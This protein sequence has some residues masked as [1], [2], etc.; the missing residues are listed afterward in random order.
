MSDTLRG[1]LL[2]AGAALT[3]VTMHLIVRAVTSGIHPLEAAFFRNIVGFI[4]LIPFLL[5]QDRSKWKSKRPGLQFI[6]AVV[7]IGALFT[8]FTALSML[9]VADATALSFTSVLFITLGAAIFLKEGLGIRRAIAIGIG[10]CGTLIIVR[11]GAGVFDTGALVALGS[12]VLWAAALL[13]VKVLA[14]TDTSVTL[15]FYTNVYFTLF[16]IV[17]AILVWTWPDPTQWVMLIAI[18]LLATLGHL[19]MTQAYKLAD[20][21]AVAPVDYSRLIWAA[22]IGYF[23][24]G[25]FPDF[26][27]WVGG[28]VIFASTVYITY[29]ESRKKKAQA[30]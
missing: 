27:T 11:P 17:P 1:A 13:C 5:R 12:T 2:I 28:T 7:G 10:F 15:V 23:W 14:R 9:P 18:G 21:T 20:A 24:F 8:W 26:W 3:V 16:S 19:L 4:V 25:E 22:A 6:R 29:R 30:A